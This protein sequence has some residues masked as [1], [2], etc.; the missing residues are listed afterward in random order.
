MYSGE[1]S[2]YQ[3]F[4][5]TVLSLHSLAGDRRRASVCL[6][7]SRPL[8][9]RNTSI[10]HI[11]VNFTTSFQADCSIGVQVYFHHHLLRGQEIMLSSQSSRSSPVISSL[12]GTDFGEVTI[13]SSAA[14]SATSG[15]TSFTSSNP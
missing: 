3:R 9:E 12:T 13:S 7:P 14:S 5:H 2:F 4:G 6:Q 8:V 10:Q 11:S 15:T 1:H